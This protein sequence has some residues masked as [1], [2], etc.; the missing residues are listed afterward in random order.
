MILQL[1]T[2][3]LY[4]W[5]WI[6]QDYKHERENGPFPENPQFDP[7]LDALAQCES[8]LIPKNAWKPCPSGLCESPNGIPSPLCKLCRREDDSVSELRT[9]LAFAEWVEQQ[10]ELALEEWDNTIV[11][12]AIP[13][14]QGNPKDMELF[15]TMK[16]T[17]LKE[18]MFHS[19]NLEDGGL[20][21]LYY[22]WFRL[23]GCS[24]Y[25]AKILLDMNI[26][27]WEYELE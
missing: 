17:A 8:Y 4:I 12:N 11:V 22:I 2:L 6:R 24:D 10:K 25:G 1:I 21:D 7:D 3:N 20:Y 15:L 23:K 26:K 13:L 14:K 9:K 27:P 18:G 16:D 5:N 19:K